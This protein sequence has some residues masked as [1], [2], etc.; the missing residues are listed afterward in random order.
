MARNARHNADFLTCY[1]DPASASAAELHTARW[2]LRLFHA[3][4]GRRHEVPPIEELLAVAGRLLVWNRAVLDATLE[5]NGLERLAE[6]K[7]IGFV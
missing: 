5:A 3:H 7:R 4:C 6:A 1:D 2:A